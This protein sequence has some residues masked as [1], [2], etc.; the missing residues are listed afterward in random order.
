MPK[1]LRRLVAGIFLLGLLVLAP[2]H[3]WAQTY[4]APTCGSPNGA[5]GAGSGPDGLPQTVTAMQNGSK[6]AY[7]KSVSNR[8][9]P[10]GYGPM[11]TKLAMCISQIEAAY[12]LLSQ[13]FSGPF[14][15]L[16]L[17]SIILGLIAQQII[18]QF[19]TALCTV[20]Q[21]EIQG[22]VKSAMNFI[23]NLICIPLPKWNFSIYFQ[24]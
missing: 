17:V 5:T 7:T 11:Q 9:Y 24:V 21:Q 4:N 2:M 22:F 23:L 6:I 18:M 15:P 12:T 20:M 8:L 16:R 13:M 3:S 19:L 1:Q 14:D 10:L